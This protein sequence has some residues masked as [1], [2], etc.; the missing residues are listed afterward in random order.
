MGELRISV[1]LSVGRT[2]ASTEALVYVMKETVEIQSDHPDGAT[3]QDQ[4]GRKAL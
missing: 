1:P 3:V 2:P 4:P